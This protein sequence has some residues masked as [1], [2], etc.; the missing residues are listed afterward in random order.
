MSIIL[1]EKNIDSIAISEPNNLRRNIAKELGAD[2]IINPSEKNY[3]EK[4]LEITNGEGFDVFIEAVGK[5]ELLSSGIS[6]L[7]PRGQALMIGVHPEQSNLMSDLYDFHYREIKLFGAFG[8]GD[9]FN[10]T[11][12]KINEFSLEKLVSKTYKLDE[13]NDAIKSTANGEGMKYMISPKL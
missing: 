6:Y 1:N 13:I 8:R 5:P 9:Y 10:D 7:R 3:E 12:K 4:L 11:P 2:H